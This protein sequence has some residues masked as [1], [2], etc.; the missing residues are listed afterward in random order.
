MFTQN[1][2]LNV[3]FYSF[4]PWKDHN[5]EPLQSELKKA[6][7]NL[8][9][10]GNILL[11]PEGLNAFLACEPLS[12]ESFLA[13][14]VPVLSQEPWC[15]PPFEVKKSWSLQ[16]PFRKLLVKIRREI[17]AF[18][19]EGIDPLKRTAPRLASKELAQWLDAGREVVLLDT[20]NDYELAV[21][22]F[23]GALDPK[24]RNFREFP[25]RLRELAPEIR[26]KPVV[27][28][29]T[30]GI[31]CEKATALA[32]EE[33][34]TEVYQLD[35]GILKYFEETGGAHWKGECFVFDHRVAVDGQLKPS[36]RVGECF[37]CRQPLLPHQL[38]TP[39]SEHQ[40]PLDRCQ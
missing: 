40:R 27:M 15:L 36:E 29:C 2:I 31:R 14:W 22:T 26:D 7:E 6:C 8:G 38:G 19:V 11:S 9:I 34:F 13:H 39:C 18:G 3:A 37:D 1:K 5:L 23:E 25:A 20:R 4:A 35:G 33:G 21:G 32:L 17:I 10:R 24:L 16:Q 28:F 30:G 12:L